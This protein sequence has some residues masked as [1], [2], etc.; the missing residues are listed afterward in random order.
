MVLAVKNSPAN[1]GDMGA[2]GSGR[3]P[4]ERRGKPLQ[5]SRLEKPTDRGAWWAKLMGRKEL[6][7]HVMKF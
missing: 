7:T 5:Y 2:P 3:S 6:D 1:A 4:A